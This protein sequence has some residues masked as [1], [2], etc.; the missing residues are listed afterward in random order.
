M[1]PFCFP[2]SNKKSSKTFPTWHLE[3]RGNSS[4]RFSWQRASEYVPANAGQFCKSFL[5]AVH[6]SMHVFYH[7]GWRKWQRHLQWVKLINRSHDSVPFRFWCVKPSFPWNLHIVTAQTPCFFDLS[8]VENHCP[9]VWAQFFNVE[10]SSRGRE[11][12]HEQI[13]RMVWLD[14]WQPFAKINV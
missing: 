5:K 4:R 3:C 2:A 7:K 12:L 9:S 8:D 11:K 13:R 10:R 14:W 6:T 1:L